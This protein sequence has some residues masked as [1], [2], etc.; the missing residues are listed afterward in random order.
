MKKFK[1]LILST[2]FLFVSLQSP[3]IAS[4]GGKIDY[5]NPRIVP[6]MSK[7]GSND[8]QFSGFLY[9][10]RIVFTAGHSPITAGNAVGL[11][12]SDTNKSVKTVSVVKKLISPDFDPRA[13][14]G[15]F[16]IYILAEDLAP[17]EPFPLM[18]PEIEKALMESRSKVQQH[19]YGIYQDLT[20]C[21]SRDCLQ[22]GMM[23]SNEPRV[24]EYTAHP[25]QDFQELVGYTRNM[26]ASHFTLFSGPLRGSCP[27][28]SGGSLTASHEGTTYYIGPTPNGMNVFA[29]GQ[30][31]DY[32]A[33]GG[34]WW[35]S[36]I[37]KHLDLLKEAEAIVA[38]TRQQEATERAQIPTKTKII[39]CL[40]GK[41]IK[42]ISGDSPKCP[43]G[44]RKG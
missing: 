39:K 5:S 36:Q 41:S 14:T 17:V 23:R 29:C 11:P 22:S 10:P 12:N 32:D 30:G 21:T 25:M 3:A 6:I 13:L 7:L 43:K 42:K 34:I 2:L 27:G 38:K 26:V 20:L 15:D 31:A 9:S 16:A 28:D 37:Y 33:R 44:Y 35:S 1:S 40:K 18:T 8:I 19:G 4:I 24:F